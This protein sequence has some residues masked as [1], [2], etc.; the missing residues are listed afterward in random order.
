[1][2]AS[3]GDHRRVAS[4]S[5]AGLAAAAGAVGSVVMVMPPSSAGDLNATSGPLKGFGKAQKVL[6]YR[7]AAAL[8][9]ERGTLNT[10]SV[11]RPYRSTPVLLAAVAFGAVVCPGV[12]LA[13][14]PGYG[15][16]ADALTVQW[17]PPQGTGADGLAVYALGFRGGSPV[18]LR[19]GSAAA[20]TVT[21]DLSGAM[22]VV[23]VDESAAPPAAAGA[24][25]AVLPV[26]QVASGRFAAG[27]TVSAI[28]ETPAGVIRNLIGAIPP[29]EAG[30]GVQDV[31]RWGAVAALLAGGVGWIRRRGAGAAMLTR[32]VHPAR[33]RAA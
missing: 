24:D 33:H 18:I 5:L 13:D 21:A 26:E 31:A 15:G 32:Y 2:P 20:T 30:T 9:P 19:V 4:Y 22:R 8:Q 7:R 11:R 12:A 23:V 1:M 29:P 25:A 3:A 17:Q 16:T 14:G 27:T 10:M 28:G 6:G